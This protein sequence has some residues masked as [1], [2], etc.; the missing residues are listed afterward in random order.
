MAQKTAKPR[1]TFIDG[2]ISQMTLKQKIGAT[3]TLAFTD[4]NS[5]TV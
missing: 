3:L 4:V 1:N 5:Q 2:L